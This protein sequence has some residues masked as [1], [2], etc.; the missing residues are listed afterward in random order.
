MSEKTIDELL[1]EINFE[2][3]KKSPPVQKRPSVKNLNFVN[4]RDTRFSK[5]MI[6]PHR[7]IKK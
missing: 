5:Y 7:G 3:K 1:D 2:V 4:T 6:N